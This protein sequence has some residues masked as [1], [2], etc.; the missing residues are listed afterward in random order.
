ML[1]HHLCCW[2]S[3][4]LL[5]RWLLYL[6]WCSLDNSTTFRGS[7]ITGLVGLQYLL[8]MKLFFIHAQIYWRWHLFWTSLQIKRSIF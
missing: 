1:F 4:N 2:R 7:W 6:T 8:M 3:Y 5:K